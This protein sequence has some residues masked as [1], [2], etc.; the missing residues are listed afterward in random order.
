MIDSKAKTG[1]RLRIVWT[2]SLKDIIDS[3]RNKTILTTLFSATLLMVMYKTMPALTSGDDPRSLALYDAGQSSLVDE[4][5]G[6]AQIDLRHMS[7][8]MDMERFLGS[9]STVALGLVIPSEFNQAV[10]AKEPIEIQGYVDHWVSDSEA[11]D[12]RAF[13]EQELAN[14]T[15]STVRI[16]VERD[17]VFTQADGW[18]WPGHHT[19]PD[20]RGKTDP[21]SGRSAGLAG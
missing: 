5:E 18:Q 12:I 16:D 3:L 21:N 10:A 13:F 20:V 11:D 2:I 14:V 1:D 6:N 9:E 7:S 17:T 19:E 15:G 8:Q 4:L